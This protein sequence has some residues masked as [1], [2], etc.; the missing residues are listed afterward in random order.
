[1]VHQD[2]MVDQIMHCKFLRRAS[3]SNTT[4]R[5]SAPLHPSWNPGC[6]ILT[7]EC[8]SKSQGRER[9]KTTPE[10]SYS[11]VHRHRPNALWSRS[12]NQWRRIHWKLSR[13]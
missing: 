12:V 13:K 10:S 5:S 3:V 6:W 7:F 11:C 4:E 9:I 1:M 2:V 8:K